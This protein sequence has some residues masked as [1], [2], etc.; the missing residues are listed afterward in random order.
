[1]V[2]EQTNM[3]KSFIVPSRLTTTD[4]R[5]SEKTLNFD[6]DLYSDRTLFLLISLYYFSKTDVWFGF[7]SFSLSPSHEWKGILFFFHR[8]FAKLPCPSFSSG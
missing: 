4:G 7:V 2:H 6:T 3:N 8:V 1:M 5:M